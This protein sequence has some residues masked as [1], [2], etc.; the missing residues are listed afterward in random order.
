MSKLKEELQ[1][2]QYGDLKAK[3]AELGIANVWKAGIKKVVLIENAVAVLEKVKSK[4]TIEDKDLAEEAII[5]FEKEKEAITEKADK[6]AVSEFE[7]AVLKIVDQKELWTKE[8]MTKRV[9]IYGNIFAQHR[10]V[11]KGIEALAKHDVLAEALKR[12]FKK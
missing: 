2:T 10:G 11:A 5:E 4:E 7:A 3:F 9:V 8:S 12:I 1:A 6:K